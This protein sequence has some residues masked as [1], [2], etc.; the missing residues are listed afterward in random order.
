VIQSSLG[1]KEEAPDQ[2]QRHE[3]YCVRRRQADSAKGGSSNQSIYC[4]LLARGIRLHA[5]SCIPYAVRDEP[6]M[7]RLTTIA[8]MPA[9]TALAV[10]DDKMSIMG[11][12]PATWPWAPGPR[13]SRS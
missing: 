3:G 13:I 4:F 9:S 10:G 1:S 6:C 8:A 7:T 11:F 5:E 2:V 12:D